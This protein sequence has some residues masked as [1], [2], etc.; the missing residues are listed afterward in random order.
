VALNTIGGSGGPIHSFY[1]I[2]SGPEAEA[3]GP[4]SVD[5]EGVHILSFYSVDSSGEHEPNQT[6]TVNIDRTPPA[7]A[8]QTSD[9][10]TPNWTVTTTDTLSGVDPASVQV[11]FDGQS[12]VPYSGPVPLDN[13]AIL[14]ARASDMAG[15]AASATPVRRI[16]DS[17]IQQNGLLT[18]SWSGRRESK[19][20][21]VFGQQVNVRDGGLL[22]WEDTSFGSGQ[23]AVIT[24]VH[25]GS[26]NSTESVLLKVQGDDP[27]VSNGAIEVRYYAK[28][29]LV[30]VLSRTPNQFWQQVATFPALFQDGDQLGARALVDGKVQVFRNGQIIGDADAGSFF[31]NRGGYI[32]LRCIDAKGVILDDFGGGTINP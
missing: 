12:F 16:L 13:H 14:Y 10:A 17:F 1:R 4:V 28:R 19:Y 15:N 31:A 27:N 6:L 18:S 8:V 5:G 26:E 29:Q 3:I 24:L 9:G 32:G 23:E 20:Y 25:T 2:D 22:Y 30:K 7:I 11:S 21:R